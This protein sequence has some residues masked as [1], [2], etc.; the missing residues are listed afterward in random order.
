MPAHRADEV[1]D[2][3]EAEWRS[4]RTPRIEEYL[5]PVAPP[6]RPALL[7]EL[8]A[9]ELELRRGRGERPM[10]AEYRQRFPKDAELVAAAFAPELPSGSHT[11]ETDVCSASGDAEFRS[12]MVLGPYELQEVLGQGAQGVVFKAR[13]RLMDRPVALK[14][15]RNKSLADRQVI[16][17][18][19]REMK[20]AARLKHGNAVLVHDAGEHGDTLYLAMEYVDG[21]DLSNLVKQRGPLPVDEACAYVCQAAQGL[22]HAHELHLVHRDVKP[23]NLLLDHEQSV[24]RILDLGLARLHQIGRETCVSD[25]L[26]SEGELLGTPDYMAPEQSINSHRAD[27]RS[28]IYGLGC[29]L[30]YLLT[31]QPPFPGGSFMQKLI[32]HTRDAPRPLSSFRADLPGGLER[33]LDRMLSKDPADRYQ[34]PAEVAQVLAPFAAPAMTEISPQPD[35][36]AADLASVAIAPAPLPIDVDARLPASPPR[37]YRRFVPIAL[38]LL[39]VGVLLLGVSAHRGLTGRN[40]PIIEPTATGVA[41]NVPPGV[42]HATDISAR[43]GATTGE[44]RRFE[45]HTGAVRSVAFSPDGQRVLSGSGWPDGD[46]TI[47]LWEVATGRELLRFAGHTAQ[48]MNV[49]FS[50]DGRRA[51]SGGNDR[52]VRLW[53][54]ESGQELRRFEG[55]SSGVDCVALS[56]DG[57]RALS[58]SDD[59]TIR[60]WDVESGRELRRFEGHTERVFSVAFSPDGRLALSGGADRT[61]R[62][63]EAASGEE[64]RR[65]GEFNGQVNS[66]AFSPDGRRALSGHGDRTLRLWEVESGQEL[67][68]FDGHAAGVT[69]VAFSSDGLRALSGSSDRTVRLWDVESGTEL[70][71]LKGHVDYVWAVAISP[72]GRHAVSG[73]GGDFSAGG[74]RPGTDF[75]LRLWALPAAVASPP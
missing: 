65:F 12:G 25:I 39:L 43:T 50:R 54:V 36:A 67:R 40:E 14:I 69:S 47:R 8:L 75:S 48:V 71:R 18:F 37:R 24:V 58:G 53:D 19:L 22:Q 2:R 31:G 3:F 49:V 38:T 45:G 64:L 63:W 17:R 15:I 10:P 46:W 4:G 11:V 68:R 51:L 16:A 26:T 52:R 59:R 5:G 61:M 20:T 62:L 42:D 57:L 30:Y 73:G 9:L 23:S 72:D 34:T 6:E 56:R 44:I 66:V 35:G 41:V 60:L 13:H 7:R 1:C 55:H 74:W 70:I 27:I 21:T 32:A 33:V 29:T 28:D